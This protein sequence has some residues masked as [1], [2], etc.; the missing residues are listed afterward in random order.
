VWRQT[1]TKEKTTY[2]KYCKWAQ[3]GLNL[4]L[5]L[6]NAPVEHFR[7][8]LD[9]RV[10]SRPDGATEAMIDS[11]LYVITLRMQKAFKDVGL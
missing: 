11:V 10:G 6:K 7:Q 9:C 8:G 5:P 3:L 2:K 1:G 4:D